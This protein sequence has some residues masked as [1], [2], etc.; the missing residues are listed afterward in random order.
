MN[1]CPT[2][3]TEDMY[4]DLSYAG[5][6][7][8]PKRVNKQLGGNPIY[9]LVDY[10]PGIM[11]FSGEEL[12]AMMNTTMI[13]INL[14]GTGG[15]GRVDLMAIG[16]TRIPIVMKTMRF[17]LE[18]REIAMREYNIHK[19]IFG[20]PGVVISEL[21]NHFI[22]AFAVVSSG[23]N[24]HIIFPYNMGIDLY[25]FIDF[26]GKGGIK[27]PLKQYRQIIDEIEVNLRILHAFGIVHFDIKPENI[28]LVQTVRPDGLIEQKAKLID[29][30]L[31]RGIGIPSKPGLGTARYHSPEHHAAIVRRQLVYHPTAVN[32]FHAFGI[33]EALLHTVTRDANTNEEVPDT[34]DEQFTAAM[35]RIIPPVVAPVP[36]PVMAPVP[37][38]V[39]PAPNH[40][41]WG[42]FGR[43]FT[44]AKT[45][46]GRRRKRTNRT[47]RSRY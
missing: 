19:A 35:Q 42:Y 28:Y 17:C 40:P 37:R 44:A 23:M 39:A 14:L 8:V 41:A 47:R 16:A 36:P 4:S 25:N 1:I 43:E 7:H 3:P 2:E 31:A 15:Q 27:I 11:P 12:I 9:T 46:G 13:P 5:N 33:I 34:V 32:D 30:G 10:I 29:F 26:A 22:P 20:R 24:I 18:S 38:P 21:M 6:R 45:Q